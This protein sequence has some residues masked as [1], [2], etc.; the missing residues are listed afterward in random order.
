MYVNKGAD[1]GYTPHLHLIRCGPFFKLIFEISSLQMNWPSIGVIEYCVSLLPLNGN[2]VMNL[3]NSNISKHADHTHAHAHN[4]LFLFH[5][6][7][8][9]SHTIFISYLGIKFLIIMNSKFCFIILNTKSR[10]YELQI[11]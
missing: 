8:S 2:V 7:L 1:M 9:L 6:S 11:S 10:H 5:L 3:I 4:I